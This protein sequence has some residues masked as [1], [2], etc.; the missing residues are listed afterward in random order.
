MTTQWAINI[1]GKED[2]PRLNY[3]WHKMH[4]QMTIV[5]HIGQLPTAAVIPVFITGHPIITKWGDYSKFNNQTDAKHLSEQ[6]WEWEFVIIGRPVM[7][8][9]IKAAAC[10]P[11][12]SDTH[13][14]RVYFVYWWENFQSNVNPCRSSG[15][16]GHPLS[17]HCVSC[18][19]FLLDSLL[20]RCTALCIT[21]K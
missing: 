12:I 16:G 5:I 13:Y 20:L 2:F 4:F 14:I 6:L 19:L 9:E 17:A 18:V 8:M 1:D 10:Y 7:K 3:F 15:L 11:V 21:K